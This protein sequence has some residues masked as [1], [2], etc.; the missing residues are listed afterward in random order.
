MGDM[1]V[2]VWGKEGVA[3]KKVLQELGEEIKELPEITGQL[4]SG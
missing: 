2:L 4:Y 3:D 1:Q